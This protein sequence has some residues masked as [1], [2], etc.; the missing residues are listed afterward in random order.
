M[1]SDSFFE[2]V[3]L[4]VDQLGVG[5]ES[6]NAGGRRTRS[7]RDVSPNSFASNKAASSANADVAGLLITWRAIRGRRGSHDRHC[8]G[9]PPFVE[10]A[11]SV[12]G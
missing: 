6:T 12:V 1:S 8:R 7:H 5:Q 2:P 11:S 3:R 10:S 9:V 4:S